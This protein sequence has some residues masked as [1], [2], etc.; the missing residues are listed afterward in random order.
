MEMLFTL[1]FGRF[2]PFD[3]YIGDW[4]GPRVELD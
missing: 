1:L 2:I 4:M 3:S